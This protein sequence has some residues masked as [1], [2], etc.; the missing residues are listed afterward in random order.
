MAINPKAKLTQNSC[1]TSFKCCDLPKPLLLASGSGGHG[2][3]RWTKG[4]LHVTVGGSHSH[5]G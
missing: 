3:V 1:E 2:E 4:G 5:Y